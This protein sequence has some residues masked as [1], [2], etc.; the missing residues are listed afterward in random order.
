MRIIKEIGKFLLA[1]SI[2][3]FTFLL[4]TSLI[5]G[6]DRAIATVQEVIGR[7][8]IVD[9]PVFGARKIVNQGTLK[10][11]GQEVHVTQSVTKASLESVINSYNQSLNRDNV[12][13]QRH[14]DKDWGAIGAFNGIKYEFVYA[15]KNQEK[16]LTEVL[17]GWSTQPTF[18]YRR[19]RGLIDQF[20]IE[21]LQNIDVASM[22]RRHNVPEETIEAVRNG[23]ISLTAVLQLMDEKFW[24][25]PEVRMKLVPIYE[26]LA[27]HGIDEVEVK[28]IPDIPRY[29][30][31]WCTKNI[32]IDNGKLTFINYENWGSV[33]GNVN[34]YLTNMAFNG[35][36]TIPQPDQVLA[37][38]DDNIK[39]LYYN[40]QNRTA[41]IGISKSKTNG[42]IRTSIVLI[43]GLI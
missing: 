6:K 20:G 42:L 23:E 4:G 3:L 9:Y 15:R 32:A 35:W 40:K 37:G 11:N 31:A 33:N 14:I 39:T 22:L 25:D 24:S 36:A 8:G 19:I 34:F 28:D 27:K 43:D 7:L 41:I 29:P 21:F 12:V 26:Y 17:T 13:L 16:G 1:L 38:I 30:T 2:I 10:V 5:I 18:N